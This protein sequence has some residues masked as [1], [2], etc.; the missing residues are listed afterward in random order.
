MKNSNGAKKRRELLRKIAA[1]DNWICHLCGEPVDP[2]LFSQMNHDWAP[3]LDHVVCKSNGGSNSQSN[4]ALAHRYCNSIRE[5][6]PKDARRTPTGSSSIYS[7]STGQSAFS[8]RV[9]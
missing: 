4:L 9:A 8:R 2:D 6:P 5:N 1:R 7:V 3:S